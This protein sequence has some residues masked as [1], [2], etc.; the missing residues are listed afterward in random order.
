MLQQKPQTAS[1][2]TKTFPLNLQQT[3][4]YYLFS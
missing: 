2:K 1:G 3:L 4:Y